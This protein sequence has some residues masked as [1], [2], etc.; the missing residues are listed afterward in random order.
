MF[1][2]FE[3][4]FF[5]EHAMLAIKVAKDVENFTIFDNGTFRYELNEDHDVFHNKNNRIYSWYPIT[6]RFEEIYK[7][8]MREV[9]T[10][11]QGLH[12]NLMNGDMYVEDTDNFVIH[13]FSENKK[14]WSFVNYLGNQKIGSLHWSRYYESDLNTEWIKN[15]IKCENY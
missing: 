10:P 3:A 14:R 12:Q 1:A 15:D 13:R 11:T 4:H 8:S 9:I 6:N 7:N 5:N 2:V